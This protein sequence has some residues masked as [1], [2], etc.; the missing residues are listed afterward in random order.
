MMPSQEI[1]PRTH[2]RRKVAIAAVVSSGTWQMSLD[3]TIEYII[4]PAAARTN[5]SGPEVSLLDIR[6]PLWLLL[7]PLS[8]LRKTKAVAVIAE[9]ISEAIGVPVN[10]RQ[11][12]SHAEQPKPLSASGGSGLRLGT[13]GQ[14]YLKG[15]KRCGGDLIGKSD[16]FGA[17]LDCVQCGDHS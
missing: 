15:C 12:W 2:E 8:G 13:Y 6:P 11:I 1:G 14:V 4:E 3:L 16:K 10:N 9:A 5:H 7:D 17:Y